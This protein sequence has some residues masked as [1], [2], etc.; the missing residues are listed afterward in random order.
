MALTSLTS[1]FVFADLGL[2]NGLLNV[3]S[4][5][6]GRSDRDTARRAVSSAFLMLSVVAVVF[7]IVFLVVYPL[8]PWASAFNVTSREAVEEI[9]P[10][11]AVLALL[12]FLALP[13]GITERVRMAYQEGFINSLAAVI[14]AIG[15]LAGLIVAIALRAS[16][17]MLVLAVSLPPVI[18]LAAN[19]IRLLVRDRPWLLPRFAEADRGTALRLARLG[20]LFVVLQV[21]VAVAYSSDVLVAA[22]VLG[23]DAAALYAVTMKVFLLVPTLVAMYLATLWPAYTEALARGDV[24][25]VKRTLRRSVLVAAAASGAA[26]LVLVTTGAWLIGNWTGG[27]I[28]PPMELLI[29]AAIWSVVGASFNAVAILMN[30]A[31]IVFF[32]VI[33]AIV[34]AAM[35]IVLS[36]AFANAFGV[37]GIV[38]GTLT[39]Y[40]V[41]SAVPVLVYLPRMLR[42]MTAAAGRTPANG[43][44]G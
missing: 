7:A 13:L 30:A 40:V 34:M 1:M 6:H 12:F 44:A 26:S 41:F 2:G 33:V 37:G 17:P 4:D 29:G 25:W 14:G 23:P 21:A 5:A 11:A 38:W 24:A 18:A 19:G 36:I 8:V 39:A 27:A 43:T 9:G 31:S 16:L 22:M 20:F 3:V 15:S 32:Q 35:S 42:T 28:Q 10:T